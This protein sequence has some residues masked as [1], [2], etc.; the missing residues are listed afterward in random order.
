MKTLTKLFLS[1]LLVTASFAAENTTAVT[2]AGTNNL[3][4]TG[5]RITQIII[6]NNVAS[7]LSVKFYDA[8]STNL[9]YVQNAYTNYVSY[10]TN[11][12]SV[13][14]TPSGISQTNT[15]SGTFT[16][17]QTVSSNSPAYRIVGT[18]EVPA[19]TTVTYVPTGGLLVINGLSVTNNTNVT[20]TTTYS[21]AR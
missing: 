11:I 1:L 5:S 14:T 2:G 3:I 19:S 6:A 20:F 9:T 7:A 8:P 21:P 16:Y 15:N 4:N 18:F 13:Y 12:V 10:T 17:A